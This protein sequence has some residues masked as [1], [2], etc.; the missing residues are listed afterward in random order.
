MNQYLFNLLKNRFESSKMFSKNNYIFYRVIGVKL[1]ED[2]VS[3]QFKRA[4]RSAGLSESIHFH[5]LR[6][7][8]AVNLA[9]KGV[10]IVVMKE[11]LGHSSIVTTMIYSHSDLDSLQRAVGK[12]DEM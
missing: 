9:L 5:T 7:S 4:V 2:Y 12:F 8:F 1:N 3:K 11:L 6:H 10:P